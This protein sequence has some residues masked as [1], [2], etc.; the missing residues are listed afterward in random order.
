MNKLNEL[1][2]E[3][4]KRHPET[5]IRVEI[6]YSPGI[7]EIITPFYY[8]AIYMNGERAWKYAGGNHNTADEA[9]NYTYRIVADAKP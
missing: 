3:L 7:R 5:L 6:V 9:V 8:C 1:Y 2:A 4:I